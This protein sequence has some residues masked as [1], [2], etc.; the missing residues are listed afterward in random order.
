MLLYR[1]F[2]YLDDAGE[3]DP[4]HT[5][6]RAP[7]SRRREV[8]QPFAVPHLL[9]GHEPRGCD[10]GSIRQ[11][12]HL[13]S[14]HAGVPRASGL[15]A[16]PR[17]LPVRRGGEPAHRLGRT[18]T[19]L[20]NV[21]SARPMS[22]SGTVPVP[23]RSPPASTTNASGPAS[24]GGRTTASMELGRSLDSRQALRRQRRSHRW[25]HRS[26]TT[27]STCSRSFARGS[28]PSRAGPAAPRAN[29][30]PAGGALG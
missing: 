1:V 13:D 10:W 15:A 11:S 7:G 9:S 20:Q 24:G 2:P 27:T 16:A 30:A 12:G 23:K 19:C 17:R 25:A 14:C 29:S 3:G 28:E 26:R 4:G 18:R 22:W 21:V 8:G 6:R 5:H